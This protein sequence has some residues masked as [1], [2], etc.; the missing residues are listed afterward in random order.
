MNEKPQTLF[1]IKKAGG[2]LKIDSRLTF[3]Y[4]KVVIAAII[5]LAVAC[6]VVAAFLGQAISLSELINFMLQ[7][8]SLLVVLPS[9]NRTSV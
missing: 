2:K 8:A 5:I 9:R 3:N 4:K 6:L 1:S 7:L